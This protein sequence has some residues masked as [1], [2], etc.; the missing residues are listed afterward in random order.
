M[1]A[2]SVLR[3]QATSVL[4]WSCEVDPRYPT[5]QMGNRRRSGPRPSRAH[6]SLGEGGR[7]NNSIGTKPG[8]PVW[9]S[10]RTPG[11]PETLQRDTDVRRIFTYFSFFVLCS[12][13]RPRECGVELSEAR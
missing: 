7:G 4:T 9:G 11:V 13:S 3:S 5:L 1:S 12:L 2:M 6:T 10:L 8:L